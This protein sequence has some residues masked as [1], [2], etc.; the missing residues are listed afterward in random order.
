MIALLALILTSSTIHA[1]GIVPRVAVACPGENRSPDLSWRG[2]P[3]G[4]RSFAIVMYDP[5]AP[6]GFFHWVAYNLPASL[7]GLAQNARLQDA[8]SG[9]NSRGATGYHGPC[10]PPG[11]PHH[12][13]TTLYALNVPRIRGAHLTGAQLQSAMRGHILARTSLTATYGR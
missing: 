7:R 3:R 12:Y 5:D 13:I 6:S 11:P 10:P 8:Q 2:V 9:I 1:G 4:T